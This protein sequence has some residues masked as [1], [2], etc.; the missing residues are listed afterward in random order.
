[1][2]R[3]IYALL[4]LVGAIWGLV[5]FY[6]Y[7]FVYYTWVVE[8]HA[9]VEEY[10]VETFSTQSAT[11]KNYDCPENPCVL[12][13]MSPIEHTITLK[14]EGYKNIV[15]SHKV[16]PRVSERLDFV[17]EKQAVLN[18]LQE[19]EITLNTQQIIQQKRDEKRFYVYFDIWN[20]EKITFLEEGSELLISYQSNTEVF[21]LGR[22]N[23]IPR[24]DIFAEYISETDDIFLKLWNESYLIKS[25]RNSLEKFPLKVEVNYI[26]KNSEKEYALVTDVGTYLYTLWDTNTEYQYLFREF[27]LLDSWEMIGVIFSDED[28]KK[29]N[30][31]LEESGNLII[32]YNSDSK[33]R[34][35]LLSMRKDIQRLEKLWEDIVVTTT[36]GK[37]VLE[38]Y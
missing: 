10:T 18:V 16:I 31:N 34:T 7:F 24:N 35:I 14:K 38:N 26:K 25:T 29:Q 30:F 37:F 9:N 1:M 33:D 22:T 32:L 21:E 2:H 6:L 19:E 5:L 20:T 28:Q 4:I 15:L 3:K 12:I 8:I 11:K 13:D 36:E 27:A 23:L 17:F